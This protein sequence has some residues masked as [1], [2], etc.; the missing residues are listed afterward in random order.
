MNSRRFLISFI[1]GIMGLV[2][3]GGCLPE[4]GKSASPTK[5]PVVNK[6]NSAKRPNIIFLLT[7]DQ[8]ND[9]LGCAGHPIVQ[10]PNIDK[11]AGDG[12]RFE[13]CFVTTSIC[14]ASRASIFTGLYERTHGYT[15]GKPA[16]PESIT[17]ESYPVLLR[18]SGYR[19]GFIG[20]YGCKL[21]NGGE[22]F[23]YKNVVQGP[24][25]YE[26]S[27]GTTQEST[28][29]IGGLANDFITDGDARPFCL[30]VSFHAS[31]AKDSNHT[32]GKGHYPYP[33]AL[34]D[35]YADQT[36]PAPALADPKYFDTLPDFFKTSMNRQR[37]FWR[38]DTPEKYQTN[39]RAYFRMLSGIDTV[40]G[41]L[42]ETLKEKGLADNTVIIY[43]ADNGYFM[44]NRGFA[45]KWNHLEES[46]RVPLVVYDPRLPEGQRGRVVDQIALNIDFAPTILDLAQVEVPE[47]YQGRSLTPVVNM[48][49]DSS[50]DLAWR[51]EFFGEHLMNNPYIPKWE[52]VRTERFKYARYFEQVPEYEFLHDLKT[53]PTEFKNLVS[54]PSY[55]D[56]LV[57][58]RAK[59]NAFALQNPRVFLAESLKCEN[60]VEPLGIDV[61]KPRFSWTS[62]SNVRGQKQTAYQVIVSTSP[63]EILSH[64]GSQW[65][66]KKVVSGNPNQVAC[67]G[68]PLKSAT[69]YHWAVKVWDKDGKAGRWSKPASFETGL[70]NQSDWNAK[71]INDGKKNPTVE[72]DFFKFDPAPLFRKDF[73]LKKR[74]KHARLYITGLGY[75]E[76]TLNG[77]RIGNN[78]LDP[79]WTKFSERVYYSTYNVTG[80]LKK[81]ENCLGVTLGN[82]WY[83]PMPLRMWGGKNLREHLAIGRPRFIS[84]LVITYRDGTTQTVNSDT[85]WKVTQGPIIRNSIYLGEIYDARKEIPGWNKAGFDDS[86]WSKPSLAEETVGELVAQTL[87]PIRA[88]ATIKP[89]KIT[90]PKEGVYI[91]DMG[92]NFSGLASFK[93][94]L[95]KG[96]KVN[97]R[98]GE[99][100]YEDGTLNPMTSVCGQIKKK[101]NDDLESRPGTA[102]QSDVYFAKGGGLEK[103]TP[104]F[105]WHAFRYLEITGVPVKPT[106]GM[107]TAVR[108]NSDVKRTGEFSCSNEMFNSIQKICDWTF[109]SNIFSVQSDC[110]HRERFGYGGD[111]VNTNETFIFNYDMA[112]F[113]AKAVTDWDDGK[114]ADG[115]LTDTAPSVG[116][117]YCGVG[118]AIAHPHTALMLY[119]YY[120]DKRII[121]EQYPTS[122]NWLELVIAKYPEHIVKR[123]LS[124]HESLTKKP[125]PPM[126]TPLYYQSAKLLAKMAGIL[127]LEDDVKRYEALAQDIKKA[128]NEKFVN[129]ETGECNPGTQSSQSFALFSDILPE[130]Q[131]AAALKYLLDDISERDGHLSTGIFGTRYILEILS[132]EGFNQTAYD[133]VNK[134]TFPSWGNML[135]NGATTLWEHWKFSDNTFSHSHPMFGSVSQWFYNWLGGI[136]ADPD[137]VGFDRIVIRPQIPNDLEWVNS[138]YDSVRGKITS[139]WR[140]A[141]DTLVMDVSIPVNTTATVYVPAASPDGIIEGE[142]LANHAKGVEFVRYENNAAIYKVQSGTYQFV[143]RR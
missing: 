54:D 132:D 27:D 134:K 80:Q 12:V 100:L 138:S 142:V 91:F 140:K 23:D 44:A 45:G 112:H 101:R 38:W 135:E 130:A 72:D 1:I 124:D 115:M 110:P 30:S 108:L 119:K 66:S 97:I 126:V 86:A 102:W 13:N 89:V 106:L 70:F 52:G 136:Q 20:K 18:K 50:K 36:M 65:D 53:D 71:W 40:V 29:T 33:M 62:T 19:T 3:L 37:Y 41:Q 121:E 103:Y 88:T 4:E 42:V 60:Q 68:A 141:G 109:L 46:L 96:T 64:K 67:Q 47:K 24:G 8:R 6:A 76:A 81:G 116:I 59:T 26:Q 34:N 43:T 99:L 137:A 5:Q 11:L 111:L 83:N 9:T 87:E 133:M 51:D 28:E 114:L 31:H 69:V 104:R 84:Q 143:V 90:E 123:G 118:W 113:Y 74:V 61:Q 58:M 39:M 131:R 49:K 25:Y 78:M 56:V 85:D 92:Q 93:F 32:P 16:I 117:Q 94:N 17:A 48:K 22:M 107:V 125:A 79:G 73:A 63:G 82:G 57:K 2:L 21:E 129:A 105:T 120:G 14:A 55:K 15:F 127:G 98:Y 75:Y 35:L 122:K 128:Y 10:T 139:N 77:R 7:D 95:K